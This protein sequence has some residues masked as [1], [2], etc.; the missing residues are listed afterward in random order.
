MY[1]GTSLMQRSNPSNT[2]QHELA[3]RRIIIFLHSGHQIFSE[4][5]KYPRAGLT[6]HGY[7]I[8]EI[9]YRDP[10]AFT[11]L[12]RLLTERASEIFCF[13]SF[14]YYIK[15]LSLRNSWAAR[16]EDSIKKTISPT[17]EILLHE[18]TDIPLVVHLCDHPLY[19]LSY[20]SSAFDGTIVYVDGNDHIDFMKKHF[21]SKSIYVRQRL[22]A[23]T[24]ISNPPDREQFFAR[25]NEIFCPMNLSVTGATVDDFWTRIKGLPA[26][27]R[28]RAT[29]LVEVALYDCLTPLHVISERLTSA[30][31]PEIEIADL[32][33]VLGFIKLWRR[34]EMIRALID[35]P[36]LVSSDF[37]PANLGRKY[38]KKLTSTSVPETLRL[39]RTFRY[40]LN[41]FPL[42]NY[43][44]HDRLVT[45]FSE[46]SVVITDRNTLTTEIFRDGTDLIFFEYN[47]PQIAAKVD[48][49]IQNPERAFQITLNMYERRTTGRLFSEDGYVSLIEAVKQKW[50]K[51][52]R[53]P[54]IPRSS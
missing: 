38:P 46:N 6:N 45:A 32:L 27:R 15:E 16:Q 39:Y 14:N 20:E 37:V 43:A 48:A 8:E 11:R 31:D 9:S 52:S 2:R 34:T 28:D 35:L 42:M 30:G 19:F 4:L 3:D 51:P 12:K 54:H 41:S 17:D 26:L 36:I 47:V 53:E 29:R 50:R 23:P 5:A 33:P 49:Y 24:L 10:E 21:R 7:A 44:L 25:R 13:Y 18:L 1:N 40:V 22:A